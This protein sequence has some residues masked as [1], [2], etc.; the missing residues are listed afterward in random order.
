MHVEA[1]DGGL[2]AE[3]TWWIPSLQCEQDLTGSQR[4]LFGEEWENGPF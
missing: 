2:D 4:M 1:K 3:E